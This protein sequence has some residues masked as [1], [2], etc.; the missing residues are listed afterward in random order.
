V[1]RPPLVR[2]D[3]EPAQGTA[4]PPPPP[5]P[6]RARRSGDSPLL[7][8]P[9][10]S[11]A[12]QIW[13]GGGCV[14]VLLIIFVLGGGGDETGRS[15]LDRDQTDGRG[16]VVATLQLPA[17][18]ARP[19]RQVCDDAG[20][21]AELCARSAACAPPAPTAAGRSRRVIRLFLRSPEASGCG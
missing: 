8:L 17:A 12:P 18:D 11:P 4:S 10:R 20:L 15:P 6:P 2:I 13:L 1:A 3:G 16:P 7:R 14:L 21:P 19:V 5:A 9:R